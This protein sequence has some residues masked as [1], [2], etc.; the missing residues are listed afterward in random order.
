MLLAQPMLVYEE[1]DA[2]ENYIAMLRSS[3][4]GDGCVGGVAMDENA[5]VAGCE[6]TRN[7]RH[8]C[9]EERYPEAVYNSTNS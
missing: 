8:G 7:V 3:D 6:C 5:N 1:E 4:D 9:K 2:A